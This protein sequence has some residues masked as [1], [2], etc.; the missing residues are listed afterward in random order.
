MT[1][2]STPVL[3]AVAKRM[4]MRTVVA[5]ACL[6]LPAGALLT[7]LGL[8]MPRFYA[9]VLGVSLTAV[10]GIFLVLRLLDIC[11][12]PAIGVLIDRTK[13]PIGRYRPWV[14]GGGLVLLLGIY[15]AFMPPAGIGPGYAILWL[16]VV[17]AGYS[18]FLLGQASWAGALTVNYNERARVYGWMQ[19]IGV[20]GVIAFLLLGQITAALV[21]QHILQKPIQFG[22]VHDMGAIGAIVM[23]MIPLAI[24]AAFSFTPER[25]VPQ[26]DKKRFALSDYLTA[27]A[28][29]NMRRIIMADLALTLGPGMTGPIYIYFFHDAKGFSVASVTALLV[30]FMGAGFIGSPFWGAVA[31]KV[32]K[33]RAVQIACIAYAIFQTTLMALPRAQFGITFLAMFV[34][35]F[36]SSCFIP[37]VRAM[38]ADVADEIRLES[39]RDLLGA[40]YAMVTTTQKIGLAVAVIIIFPVLG[41]VGYKGDGVVNTPNAIFGLEMCYLFA[42]IIFVVVGLLVLLGYKLDAKRHADVRA[43]LD[44]RDGGID[45]ASAGETLTG[46]GISPEP[47]E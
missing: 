12:D 5:F 31:Q 15:R 37:V 17:Y 44:L 41:M 28:K 35:G 7:I 11:L 47:A 1:S 38:V 6:N 34:V 42:P 25:I 46:I 33:H 19:G 9:S 29:P 30:P 10:G 45:V 43:A 27:I 4:P 21:H 2:I 32:G 26:G 16:L 13:T 20:A 24:L 3:D 40:L 39:G 23:V 36:C 22:S 8:L 14:L 18:M